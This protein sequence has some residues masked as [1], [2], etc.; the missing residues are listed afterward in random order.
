[1]PQNDMLGHP[2]T[3]AFLSHGG[4]NGLYEVGPAPSIDCS[5]SLHAHKTLLRS[6]RKAP[7]PFGLEQASIN[8]YDSKAQ[9]RPR[10]AAGG[11]NIEHHAD[12]DEVLLES[13]DP[14]KVGFWAVCLL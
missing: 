7:N 13:V 4:V 5:P 2:R 8:E 11:T 3:M 12:V 9:E 6:C 10:L 1:M 14:G